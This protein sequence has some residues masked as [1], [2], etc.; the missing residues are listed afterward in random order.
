MGEKEQKDVF[1]GGEEAL[2]GASRNV[3]ESV[4]LKLAGS[5]EAGFP[6][7]LLSPFP[8]LLP[9]PPPPLPWI[10]WLTK[11]LDVHTPAPFTLKRWGIAPGI[12]SSLC[13]WPGVHLLLPFHVPFFASAVSFS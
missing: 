4:S 2:A 9:C 13:L 6:P 5:F 1:W 8:T 10:G 12:A 3:H 11:G 7:A